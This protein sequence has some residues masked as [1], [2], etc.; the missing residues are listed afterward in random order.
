MQV[1]VNELAF[2]MKHKKRSMFQIVADRLN[3]KGIEATRHAV[4]NEV[5]R[6][7]EDY[8]PE[9][10]EEVREVFTFQTGKSYQQEIA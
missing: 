3:Q 8:R 10:I 6:I 7:K 1:D 5:S 9:I 2:I 4:V